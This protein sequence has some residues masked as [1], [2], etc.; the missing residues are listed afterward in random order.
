[1]P[2]SS[3]S[4]GARVWKSTVGMLRIKDLYS[5][6]P[7]FWKTDPP[8]PRNVP[9]YPKLI[10]FD[11]DGTF[12]HKKGGKLRLMPDIERILKDVLS[13]GMKIAICSNHYPANEA[14]DFFDDT[15]IKTNGRYRTLRSLVERGCFIIRSGDKTVHFNKV[16]S[17]S[18]IDCSEMLFFDDRTENSNVTSL[19]VKFV[20]VD[21]PGLD[22]DTYETA[23]R[24]FAGR[25][26]PQIDNNEYFWG[27]HL[28]ADEERRQLR[29]AVVRAEREGRQVRILDPTIH[30][31]EIDRRR[32]RGGCRQ[33]NPQK[34]SEVPPGPRRGGPVLRDDSHV[35]NILVSPHSRNPMSRKDIIL[36]QQLKAM[37]GTWVVKM[38]T[39]AVHSD[40]DLELQVLAAREKLRHNGKA[41]TSDRR[42]MCGGRKES[43]RGTMKIRASLRRFP[44]DQQVSPDG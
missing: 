5:F 14:E 40:H 13:R 27:L 24:N 44:R 23:L 19:G 38:W 25:S 29:E 7:E 31:A 12:W 39:I 32:F 20:K 9:M 28:T 18:G 3:P 33:K 42:R 26:Q 22:W 4:L 34:V 17:R 6:V 43:G 11:L 8:D 1:M 30:M 35:P 16:Q 10:A 15:S 37:Y 21:S 2:I 36:S 41:G